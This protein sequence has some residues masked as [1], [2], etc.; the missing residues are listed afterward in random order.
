MPLAGPGQELDTVVGRP[1]LREQRS[2]VGQFFYIKCLDVD[3][4]C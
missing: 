1:D 2:M 4:F 3:W